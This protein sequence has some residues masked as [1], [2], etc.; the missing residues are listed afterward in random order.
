MR[1]RALRRRGNEGTLIDAFNDPVD[2]V[3]GDFGVRYCVHNAR[4]LVRQ[5]VGIEPDLGVGQSRVEDDCGTVS[6]SDLCADGVEQHSVVLGDA[7]DIVTR[8]ND[9]VD[10]P[11]PA[12]DLGAA[13]VQHG[14]ASV[15]HAIRRVGREDEDGQ[16]IPPC[17]FNRVPAFEKLCDISAKPQAGG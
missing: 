1:R 13:V 12:D 2:G 14:Y 5:T 6:Q 4:I 9:F 15:S 11:D 16:G 8:S 10:E 17:V 7:F 3:G